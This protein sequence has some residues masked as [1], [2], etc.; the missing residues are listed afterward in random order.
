VNNGTYSLEL[1]RNKTARFLGSQ[2]WSWRR[3]GEEREED[4]ERRKMPCVSSQE[5]IG[6]KG[7]QSE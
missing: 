7:E 3:P 5:S 6:M 1:G 2:A 4:R